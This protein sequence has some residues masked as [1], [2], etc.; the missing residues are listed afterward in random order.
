MNHALAHK[1]IPQFETKV[2]SIYHMTHLTG[3]L[4]II[5]RAQ[6]CIDYWY[7]VL[8]LQKLTN[9]RSVYSLCVIEN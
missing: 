4:L 2:A 8:L 1:N 7:D 9:K 3:E 5:A 6:A